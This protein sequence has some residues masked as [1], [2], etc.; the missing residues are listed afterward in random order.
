[1]FWFLCR[2][3]PLCVYLSFS[4]VF[5]VLSPTLSSPLGLSLSL[6]LPSL[7][8]PLPS[9][10]PSIVF[11]IAEDKGIYIAAVNPSG[12]A[13]LTGLI[14]EG[15][16]ILCVNGQSLRGLSNVDATA[17]LKSCGSTVKLVLGRKKAATPLL[18]DKEKVKEDPAKMSQPTLSHSDSSG[19]MGLPSSWQKEEKERSTGQEEAGHGYEERTLGW[20]FT[21]KKILG[22]HKIHFG[23]LMLRYNVSLMA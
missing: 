21:Y 16:K 5:L 2:H 13:G 10:F 20:C 23:V 19:R 3:S 11:F 1:M 17:T 7:S 15:D 9:H 4:F 14:R 18:N 6:P 12:A 8:L 22:V